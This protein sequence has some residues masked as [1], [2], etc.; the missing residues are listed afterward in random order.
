M[1][2]T[3]LIV[4]LGL[5][6]GCLS[7]CKG[8]SDSAAETGK[9]P[10]GGA[11]VAPATPATATVANEAANQAGAQTSDSSATAAPTTASD[12]PRGH[13]NIP[14]WV[15]NNP[16]A[17][18]DVHQ[19]LA[20]RRVTDNGAPLYLAGLTLIGEEM[21]S[22]QGKSLSV[23]VGRLADL[24]KLSAGTV[25]DIQIERVLTAAAPAIQQIDAAQAKPGTVFETTFNVDTL[26]PHVQASRTLARLSILQLAYARTKHDFALA[27]SAIR[28][29]LRMSRDLQPRGFAVCQLVS[30]AIDGLILQGI[31]RLT[32]TDPQLT[33]QQ[34]DQLLSALA[35]HEQRRMDQYREALQ[36]EYLSTCC[37]IADLQSGRI[38]FSEMLDALGAGDSKPPAT[39]PTFGYPV[40]IA[41]CHRVFKMALDESHIPYPQWKQASAFRAEIDRL[42]KVAREANASGQ[43]T[44]A[45][46][47]V[48]ITAPAVNALRDAAARNYTALAGT[49]SL[50]ALR[51]YELAHKS[52]PATLESAFAETTHKNVPTDFYSAKPLQYAMV[53]GK[54]IIYSVGQDLKDDGGRADWKWG[55]Q[56]GDFLFVFSP[57]AGTSPTPPVAASSS[58]PKD[59]VQKTVPSKLRQWKSTVG[60]TLEAEFVLIERNLAVLKKKDGSTIRVPL[61][62]LSPD[63][64]EW[65]RNTLG[66]TKL[67]E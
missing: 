58:A 45:A 20:S 28:R 13:G 49:Q 23:E 47:L 18:F 9:T 63:D 50:I 5:L 54:P 46:K 10:S 37:S 4:A 52:L 25:P 27:E 43:P 40:E 51:R 41:A 6:A 65:I 42:L 56:P 11:A 3:R 15:F 21:G 14:T 59:A 8:G 1:I 22:S 39:E 62:K 57:Q 32:I 19:Y 55:E 30:I 33:V 17:A 26:L 67:P 7:A 44:S 12:V 66:V 2:S 29:G 60:T 16:E 53:D 31:Q 64:Q 24:D 36:T 48:L 61:A 38:K 34:C 35:E